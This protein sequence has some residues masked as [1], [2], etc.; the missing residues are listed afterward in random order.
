HAQ[1]PHPGFLHCGGREGDPQE[2][3]LRPPGCG[4]A[5]DRECGRKDGS[6]LF[7]LRRGRRV[8]HHRRPRQCEPRRRLAGDQRQRRR[9]HKDHGPAY[10]RR[11][12]Q[13]REEDGEI[14][15]TWPVAAMRRGGQPPTG[16]QRARCRPQPYP[17]GREILLPLCILLSHVVQRRGVWSRP[18]ERVSTKPS[19]IPKIVCPGLRPS[20]SASSTSWPCSEPPFSSRSSWASTST[21]CSSSA[22]SPP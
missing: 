9:S 20:C 16:R 19:I 4:T 13:G 7:C 18:S 10:A 22:G 14:P 8:R 21:R 2:R 11:D 6:V 17:G 5:G 3:G 1:V 15:P 12:R